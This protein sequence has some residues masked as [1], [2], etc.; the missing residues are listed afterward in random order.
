MAATARRLARS[1]YAPSAIGGL[2][3]LAAP[4]TS[5]NGQKWQHVCTEGTY[6]GHPKFTRIDWTK[7]VFQ[8]LV[9]NLRKNPSYRAGADG[10]GCV[11]VIPWDYE[12]ANEIRREKGDIPEEGLPS[13]SWTYDLDVRVGEDGKSQLWALTEWLPTAKEQ[14]TKGDYQFCSVCVAT[15]YINPVS[16]ED[17]GPTLTSIALT[18]DPFI[19]GMTPLTATLE[20]WGP[21]E[22]KL[23]VLVAI[24]GILEMPQDAGAAAVVASLEEL[25]A[26]VGAGTVPDYV[27]ISY[28]LDRVR[29]LMRL[30]LLATPEEILGGAVAALNALLTD[31]AGSTA[32]IPPPDTETS[33]SAA[34]IH[35]LS[36]IL[37]CQA[38]EPAIMHAAQQAAKNAEKAAEA[39]SAVGALDQLKAL[40]GS[41]DTESLIAKATKTIADAKALE[42]AVAALSE[43]RN[44]L[45]GNAEAEAEQEADAVTASLARGDAEFAKRIRPVVLAARTACITENGT[46]DAAKLDKFRA[47][48]PL[49]EE[50]KALLSRRVVAGPNGVQ[51][52]GA[53]TG[54]GTAPI[55]QSSGQG[56]ASQAEDAE[57]KKFVDAINASPGNNAYDK[58]NNLL[59]SRKA[60][61]KD[62]PLAEQHRRAGELTRTVLAGKLPVDFK[63]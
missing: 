9:N 27:D 35:T 28:L 44:A 31:A 40:F 41:S 47:D 33:M 32:L 12:H 23:E 29:R 37:C 7:Q 21:A 13:A 1:R 26:A 14:I 17:Q 51:L 8:T 25:L 48:Y 10:F 6:L 11:R 22:S 36:S 38:A 24:R 30:P 49:P 34:L 18:N 20:Q 5:D 39:Q 3:L 52:G 42:P 16:G 62:L 58:A 55:T 57:V 54:Y 19:Q 63:L 46:V 4:E 15:K 50:S 56:G 61:H 43:V 2:V 45:K 53:V 59:C 60:G